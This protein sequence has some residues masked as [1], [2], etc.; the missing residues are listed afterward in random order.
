MNILISFLKEF[1]KVG[2][3]NGGRKPSIEGTHGKCQKHNSKIINSCN[4]AS[5]KPCSTV[6]DFTLDEEFCN[7]NVAKLSSTYPLLVHSHSGVFLFDVSGPAWLISD[8]FKR[9]IH[10]NLGGSPQAIQSGHSK[11]SYGTF[12]SSSTILQAATQR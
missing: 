12:A 3:A 10:V 6:M 2:T 5:Q 7:K 11:E 1:A 8:A 4:R 9:K